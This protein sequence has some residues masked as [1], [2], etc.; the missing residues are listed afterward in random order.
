MNLQKKLLTDV[1]INIVIN[2]AI[3]FRGLLLIPI[4][5]YTLGVAAYG[6]FIQLFVITQLLSR[7]SGMGLSSALV[8]F[9]QEKGEDLPQLY[10]SLTVI[11]L[12]SSSFAGILVFLGADILSIY[13]LRSQEYAIIFELGALLVPLTVWSNMLLNYFRAEMSIKL[14]SL[15]EGVLEYSIAAAVVIALYFF[16]FEIAGVIMLVVLFHAVYVVC[17]QMFVIWKIGVK[18]PSLRNNDKYIRYSG[19]LMVSEL[20]ANVTSKVDRLVIGAFIGASAVGI[21]SIVYRTVSVLN[22][23]VVPITAVFFPEFSRLLAK[24]RD[25]EVVEYFRNGVYYF[26]VLA[27]PSVA[28]LFLVG[29]EFIRIISDE[30]TTRPLRSLI[31]VLGVGILCYSLD[32]LYGVIPIA[33]GKSIKLSAARSSGAILN[34]VINLLLVSYFG[35]IG[36]AIATMLTYLFSFVLVYNISQNIV[37]FPFEMPIFLKSSF[38]AS[39]MTLIIFVLLPNSFLQAIA[40][41]PIIYFIALFF[42][43]GIKIRDISRLISIL[44]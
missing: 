26:L 1:Y 24:D 36:A 42:L 17:L 32:E 5:T 21:Y 37:T 3:R 15:L 13:T 38:S 40:I 20:A 10:F 34:V 4:F 41:G 39:V 7:I 35:I 22:T 9:A 27:I 25:E 33:A 19:P 14:F 18:K 44:D 8:N 29:P 11:G 16:E 12:I 2:V 31:F 23:Y 6:V 28:G 43:G 30:P